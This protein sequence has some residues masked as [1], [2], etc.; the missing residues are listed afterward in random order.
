MYKE[1]DLLNLPST[2]AHLGKPFG[3]TL[4]AMGSDPSFPKP[5]PLTGK[6]KHWRKGDLDAWRAAKA[7]GSTPK[8]G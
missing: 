5:T 3:S 1:I 2:L 8:G 6:V 7:S 4:R